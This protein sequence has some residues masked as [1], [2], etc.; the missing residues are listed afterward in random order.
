MRWRLLTQGAP[1]SPKIW[2]DAYLAAFGELAG[3]EI[4][5]F[6]RGF[7]KFSNVRCT[8]LP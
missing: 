2:K 1:F 5:T 7:V 3:L 6:D 4:I 8:I